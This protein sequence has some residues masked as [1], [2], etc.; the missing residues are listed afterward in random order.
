[1]MVFNLMPHH[2][3]SQNDLVVTAAFR[4]PLLLRL[5]DAES[6][7][8]EPSIQ[9][10]AKLERCMITNITV[11]DHSTMRTQRK[12]PWDTCGGNSVK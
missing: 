1:M 10:M 2:T 4:V 6:S 8:I 11:A 12:A 5:K 9:A 7:L 3:F